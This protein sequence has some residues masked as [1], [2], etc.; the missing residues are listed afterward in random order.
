MSD[1]D[2]ERAGEIARGLNAAATQCVRS[3][4]ILGECSPP[5]RTAKA[6]ER[7]G[8]IEGFDVYGSRRARLTP[9]GIAVAKIL[10]D[11]AQ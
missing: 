11:K 5:G 7:K 6:L 9:L 8:L 10:K 2:M 1:A 3:M 4:S